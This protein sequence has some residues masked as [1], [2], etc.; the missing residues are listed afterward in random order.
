MVSVGAIVFL[1]LG[2]CFVWCVSAC[3]KH[4]TKAV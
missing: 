1:Q 2:A 4:S 3:I